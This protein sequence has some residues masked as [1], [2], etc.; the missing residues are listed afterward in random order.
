VDLYYE[1]L[2]GLKEHDMYLTISTQE[3]HKKY[4][5]IQILPSRGIQ[6][7]KKDEEGIPVHAKSC[8]VALGKFEDRIWKKIEKFAP[9]LCDESAHLMT[10]MAIQMD[11]IK[12][13]GMSNKIEVLFEKTT[14][15]QML[16]QLHGQ[17]LLV[18]G[19]QV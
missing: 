9:I 19:F 15:Y 4:S 13:Q 18:H 12:K 17:S 7:I 14:L 3:Y 2:N 8:I 6:T 10:S 16:C 11:H 1:E 5:G